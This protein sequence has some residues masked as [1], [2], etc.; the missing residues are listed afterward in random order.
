MSGKWFKAKNVTQGTT[1]IERVRRADSFGLRLRGLTFRRSLGPD[2]GLLLVGS[3]PSRADS[4]I[5]MFFVFFAIGV[6][7]LDA[8]AKV[9]DKTV[10]KPFRPFYA[11]QAPALYVLECQPDVVDR[12]EIGDQIDFEEGKRES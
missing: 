2:E 10:A 6:L 8:E 11:P 7:W 5:H 3:R 1:L 9:V 4:A 12:V